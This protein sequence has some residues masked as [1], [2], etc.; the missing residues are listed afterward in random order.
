MVGPQSMSIINVC[1][2]QMRINEDFTFVTNNRL[3]KLT[4][5]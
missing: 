4:H 2:G 1:K 3:H 5:E